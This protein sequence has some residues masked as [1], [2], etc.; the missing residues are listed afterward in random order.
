VKL[1][2]T[3]GELSVFIDN[4]EIEYRYESVAQDQTCENVEGLAGY[5]SA[6]SRDQDYSNEYLDDGIEYVI[7]DSTKTEKYVF[8]ISW[9]KNC[10][11]VI[12]RKD[13][14]LCPALSLMRCLYLFSCHLSQPYNEISKKTAFLALCRVLFFYLG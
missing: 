12:S 5:N 9:I 11:E 2:T 1:A 6:E 14:P 10:T 4:T 8:G 7:L 13:A 3:L